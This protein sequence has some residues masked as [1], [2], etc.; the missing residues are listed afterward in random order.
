MR[1]TS[2][3]VM[4]A[5][6]LAASSSAA[7]SSIAAE[8][9]T[10]RLGS[11]APV[12]PTTANSYFGSAS[13]AT[14]D[15]WASGI[16][17]RPEEFAQLARALRHDPDLIY[18]YVRNNIEYVPMYG[19]QKGALGAIID[20]SG[21]AF[22]QA[23][24]MVEL[25]RESGY[26][27]KYLA[28]TITLSGAQI[29]SWL[30][31]TN[32]AALAKI[33][34]DGGIP[35]TVSPATGTVTSATLGHV[36]V[37][38]TIPGSSC[39]SSCIFDPAYKPTTA[40]A[41]SVSLATAMQWDE[42]QFLTAAKTGM[43][44]GSQL[45]QGKSVAA[46][47]VAKINHTNI[48]AKLKTY[49]T[50]LLTYLKANAA[51]KELKEIIGGWSIVP[52]TT[53]VRQTALPYTSSLQKTWTGNIP[54]QY[55]TTLRIEVSRQFPPYT[56][57]YPTILDR[58][59]FADEFYGRRVQ[60][61]NDPNLRN[62]AFTLKVDDV[63]V[64]S[65]VCGTLAYQRDHDVRF[66][67]NHPYPA[68]DTQAGTGPG[69]YMDRQTVIK[70]NLAQPAAIMAGFGRVSS[71]LL[72]KISSE[73]EHEG[74]M[75]RAPYPPDTINE[76]RPPPPDMAQARNRMTAAWL[77][78][79]TRAGEIQAQIAG[80]VMQHHHSVGITYLDP[81]MD[82]V[83]C[84]TTGSGETCYYV[85][86][87]Q[88]AMSAITGLSLNSRTNVALDR[89]AAA[90]AIALTGSALE[91]SVSEQVLDAPQPAS[92]VSRFEW[93]NSVEPNL[94]RFYLF[95]QNN[96]GDGLFYNYIASVSGTKEIASN[97]P[98]YRAIRTWVNAGYWVLAA[99][100][101]DLGPG[102]FWISDQ[103]NSGQ[104]FWSPALIHRGTAFIAFKPDATSISHIVTAVNKEN[105]GGGAAADPDLA[106]DF[107]STTAAD[108]MKDHFKDRSREF[109]VDLR[110][111]ELSYT[112]PA[113]ITVGN[114]GFPYELSL[115]RSF[116]SSTKSAPG[117]AQ[118]WSHNFDIRADIGGNGME[119][120]GEN[121][122]LAAVPTLVAL[123]VAQK[124]YSTTPAVDQTTLQRW[125]MAP[126]VGQWWTQQLTYN[127]VTITEGVNGRQFV[128]MPDGS[129]LPPKGS[130]DNLVQSGQRSLIYS[131]E[132]N[133]PTQVIGWSYSALS[134]TLTR[135]DRQV[136]NFGYYS[137][138]SRN[139]ERP[140]WD[141]WESGPYHGWH[142]T[143]WTF[144][145]GMSLT[146][147]YD[148]TPAYP[149]WL[150]KV[151]NSL[152]REIRFSYSGQPST[153]RGCSLAT[154]SDGVRPGVQYSCTTGGVTMPTGEVTRYEYESNCVD[155]S[156]SAT[157]VY[158]YTVP[159][160]SN[161]A[162]RPH[163]GKLLKRVF[164]PSDATYAKQEFGYDEVWRASSYKDAVAVKTP[165]SRDPYQFYITGT[166]RGERL[167][168]AGFEYLVYYDDKGRAIQFIDELNRVINAKY[169]GQDRI[170]ERKYPEGN[171]TC[172][173]YDAKHNVNKLIQKPKGSSTAC[174]SAVTGDISVSA[175]YDASCNAI[176]SVTDPRNYTTNW[177]YSPTTC[178][179][180]KLEQP[181]VLDALTATHKRPT[182]NYSQYNSFGQLM[183]VTDP[184]GVKAD[185]TYF[186]DE[187]P[188]KKG[189]RKTRTLDAGAAPHINSV[190]QYDYDAAGNVTSVTD[191]RSNI[192]SY[193]YDHQRRVKK[194]TAPLCAVTEN[195]YTPDGQIDYFRRAKKCS[196]GDTVAADWQKTDYE[197]TPTNQVWK[198]FDPEGTVTE[199]LYDVMDRP[200][201]VIQG[202]A[203]GQVRKTKTIY[204]AAGQVTE[205]I[206]A[207][208]SADQISYAR[209]GYTLNG[210]KDWVLDANGN[211]TDYTYDTLDRLSRTD[212]PSKITAGAVNTADYEQYGYDNSS[213]LTSKR[214]RTGK[215]ITFAYDAL[216][217]E[218]TRTVP[219]N[220]AGLYARTLTTNYDLASRKWDLTAESQTL[221]HRYDTA[222]RLDTV[223]DALITV[224]KLDY[225]YDKAGNRTQLKV[226][227]SPAYVLDYAYDALN[228]MDT[229]KE[230]GAASFLADYTYDT[231]SRRDFA[232][233]GNGTTA[234][235]GYEEDDDL[236]SLR[237]VV[238]TTTV[239]FS[240]IH[241]GAHQITGLTSS[242]GTL[243]WKPAANA[244]NAY[245]PN[246]LN[247]I[248][249]VNTATVTYDANGN[250]TGDGTWTYGYDE[251]NR[252]RKAN[253]TGS[254]ITYEYDPLGRRRAKVVNN[255]KTRYLSDGAE[256]IAEYDGAA[257]P[258]LLRRYIYGPGI[259]NRI[260]MKDAAGAF[261]FYHV[262]HQGSTVML[263]NAARSVVTT[264]HYGPYGE[265]TDAGAG[266]P[267]RYVGRRFDEES[268]LYYWRARYYSSNIGRFLQSDPVGYKD[269]MNLYAF[270]GNDPLN[271]T[272]PTG[273]E[274]IMGMPPDYWQAVAAVQQA[275]T[276]SREIQAKASA[277]IAAQIAADA[278]SYESRQA[279]S[280][281]FALGFSIASLFPPAT[282]IAAP[283]ALAFGAVHYADQT[284]TEGFD[285][286]E[287]VLELGSI[288]LGPM[289]KLAGNAD[290]VVDTANALHHFVG[291]TE[292][293]VDFGESIQGLGGSS[294]MPI[295]GV[296]RVGGRIDSSNIERHN[297]N[298]RKCERRQNEIPSC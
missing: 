45:A 205:I 209:Y 8:L 259:D 64:S 23:Q 244:V 102:N 198:V 181:T 223:E 50:N 27:A 3:R 270:V 119:T 116:R 266:N 258:A 87:S 212:F 162:R 125:I 206:K 194:L 46:P 111:G 43:V 60:I 127:V 53:V 136:Q 231:L 39:S 293:S 236:A 252:L 219:A 280:S 57:N 107:D 68:S 9:P 122:P 145:T 240:Y 186:G 88:T 261:S 120:M 67:V 224:G 151:R 234:D 211:K 90:Q 84:Q 71:A 226:L 59:L 97:T 222:G 38:A 72:S 69:T 169:D 242:D 141:E 160:C 104:T 290:E 138:L 230:S 123:F 41:A 180:S 154:I 21:T 89:T 33:F 99:N 175:T 163:Y 142:I 153:L 285:A 228:R 28:G 74:F 36:W 79:L 133:A 34:A 156:R 287:T 260:A 117:L 44:S 144:P 18:E 115:Q 167:D 35:A 29:N 31:V 276:R 277:Q 253:K 217:R 174:T 235:P 195:Y 14:V 82:G 272:D 26:T 58:L 189:Y 168:P 114:G 70:A 63:V 179:L 210:Q 112:A 15:L 61:V 20:Q 135:P 232:T 220:A 118:G 13:T 269:D 254:T 208:G 24:L 62:C 101:S 91:G 249:K 176:A 182:T 271:R 177:T 98:A 183:S 110:T 17:G 295:T 22:D 54:D 10:I 171:R 200:E 1:A 100:Q 190:T 233:W 274:S 95:N 94:T 247:Q 289:V 246:G 129:F 149:D 229:V 7:S 73:R 201:V 30:G 172:F 11:A 216:N 161:S 143:S 103:L 159:V 47:Y 37:Q 150:T 83:P 147:E 273:T 298:A 66:T 49:S 16:T 78:Q 267:F 158:V 279:A 225:E 207:W 288:A 275:A 5:T 109:G 268:G 251:E 188:S 243:L 6:I 218:T 264:Y 76:D 199:T 40:V 170:T 292:D 164:M 197:Y 4:F 32:A 85:A 296:V 148:P 137:R 178:L 65:A 294:A 81:I 166:N 56:P 12:T 193:T 42:A 278:T 283:S 134:F 152:G 214:N 192:T 291:L 250:L 105:K 121:N 106:N 245:T 140:L 173:G 281:F 96:F 52:N 93:G 265:T 255:V 2:Y 51:S 284:A 239:D 80:V 130:A 19:L 256:E 139:F 263:S 75:P 297:E 241:N 128:R 165:S 215:S 187:A 202:I 126:F 213:N 55:R 185:Y 191:P 227:S 108:L 248:T 92:T 86:D 146:F 203:T 77:G 282:P 286:G 238:G 48:Q 237:H 113:D 257:T 196:P 157:W 221:K 25:L 184:T 132:T 204:D 262:N 124:L 131:T 155:Q